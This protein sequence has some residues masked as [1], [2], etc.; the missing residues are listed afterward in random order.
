MYKLDLGKQRDMPTLPQPVLAPPPLRKYQVWPLSFHWGFLAHPC[1]LSQLR[2]H[3][4]QARDLPAAELNG[5]SNPLVII[6][7]SSR[8]A[9][10]EARYMTLHPMWYQSLC[11]DNVELPTV[12]AQAPEISILVCHQVP[13]RAYREELLG[14]AYY[15]VHRIGK[16]QAEP[17]WVTLR[18]PNDDRGKL[19]MSLQLIP[20]EEAPQVKFASIWP[21]FRVRPCPCR[22]RVCCWSDSG[23]RRTV[24]WRWTRLGCAVSSRSVSPT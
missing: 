20:V 19:L 2:A 15:P 1:L 6:R 12:L 13:D 11:L 8:V 17:G 14:R 22:A 21:Q 4:Y 18:Y 3:I 10:T 9:K 7:C 24:W 5:S 16:T 23:W